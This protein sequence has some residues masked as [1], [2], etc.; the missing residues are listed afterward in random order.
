MPSKPDP[1]SDYKRNEEIRRLARQLYRNLRNKGATH[2][3]AL[4]AV[5]DFVISAF[6]TQ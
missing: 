2:E 1:K 6:D 5:I 4:S 3:S